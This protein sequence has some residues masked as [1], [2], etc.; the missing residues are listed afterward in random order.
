MSTSRR[1]RAFVRCVLPLVACAFATALQAQE[2]PDVVPAADH[3][4]ARECFDRAQQDYAAGRLAEARRGF[5]CAYA[6]LPS[7]ELAWNLGRVSERMGD[8]EEGLRY[9]QEYLAMAQP[10][11]EERRRVEARIA[12]LRKLGARQSVTLKPG[13]DVG[14]ALS[15]EA[16]AFFE[17]GTKLYRAGHYKAAA[18]AFTAALQLS[19][20]PELHYNLG[21]TAE[22]MQQLQDACDHYRAYLEAW[23][24]APD[25]ADV[26]AHIGALRSQITG[27]PEASSPALLGVEVD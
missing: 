2:G 23:P 22:R 14:K 3:E 10:P 12:A 16:R 5:E 13:P 17:R 1:A 8:V 11:R 21:V 25:R 4:R 18:A 20:A 19:A 27:G 6:Q 7:S 26:R 15:R 9:F 24:E